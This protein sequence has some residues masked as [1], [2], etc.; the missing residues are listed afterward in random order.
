MWGKGNKMCSYGHKPGFQIKMCFKKHVLPPYLNDGVI[1]FVLNSAS[2]GLSKLI[3][4]FETF[5]TLE[6]LSF[7]IPKR[8][9]LEI[10]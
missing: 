9:L 5:Q 7:P 10:S 3:C 1:N 8:Q 6:R 4:S 2:W